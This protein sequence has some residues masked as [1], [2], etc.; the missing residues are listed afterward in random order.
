MLVNCLIWSLTLIPSLVVAAGI[1]PNAVTYR[2]FI[3]A[4]CKGKST[5]AASKLFEEMP[6]QGVALNVLSYTCIINGHMVKGI[7]I[8]R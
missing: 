5:G 8:T 7:R 4:L 2:T 1:A 3:N 6:A